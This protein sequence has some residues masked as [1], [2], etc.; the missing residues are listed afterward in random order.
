MFLFWLHLDSQSRRTVSKFYLLCLIL[1]SSYWWCHVGRYYVVSLTLK[2]L[3]I[4]PF[5]PLSLIMGYQK[6][7]RE[8]YC[9][10][11]SYWNSKTVQN[12]CSKSLSYQIWI[13]K[14]F[15]TAGTSE[16]SWPIHDDDWAGTDRQIH[17]TKWS[18]DW[19]LQ[20]HWWN[21]LK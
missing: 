2:L 4:L 15:T 19:D 20:Y 18:S 21:V 1:L 16:R 17:V 11:V 9:Q 6:T 10:I 3:L 7:G 12:N 5:Y 14:G 13:S 8:S